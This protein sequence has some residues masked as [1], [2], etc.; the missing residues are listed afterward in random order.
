MRRP[1]YFLSIK[2][3]NPQI[4][5]NV[6]KIQE[7]LSQDNATKNVDKDSLH[8]TLNALYLDELH[9]L[10]K[11]AKYLHRIVEQYDGFTLK[12]VGIDGFKSSNVV[13]AKF[14]E[15]SEEILRILYNDI[16]LDKKLSKYVV[17]DREFNPHATMIRGYIR[18]FGTIA[19][20]QNQLIGEQ[21]VDKLQLCK[22]SDTHDNKFNGISIHFKK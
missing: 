3:N 13:Y 22:F 18:K 19:Q 5:E 14:D 11:A 12:L 16:L 15:N 21:Y 2:L 20:E 10:H 6:F 4:V 17:E 7:C 9:C 8:V 1:N